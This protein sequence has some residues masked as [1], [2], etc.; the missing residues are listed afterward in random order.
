MFNHNDYSSSQSVELE[1]DFP[2]YN[3]FYSSLIVN[4]NGWVGFGD[5][6]TEWENTPIPS[7]SA[8][9]PAIFGFWDDLNPVNDGGTGEG[10]VYYHVSSEEV[11][12]C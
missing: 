9:R 11:P 7:T 6:N 3:S 8:P 1:F 5:D 10:N 2:F 12:P 4:P